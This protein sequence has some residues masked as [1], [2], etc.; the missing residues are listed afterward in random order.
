MIRSMT[1]F[2]AGRGEGAGVVVSAEVKSTNGRFL[3]LAMRL[4]PAL[5]ARE[6]ELDALV[7]T[8]LR[9]GSAALKVEL[10]EERPEAVVKVDEDVVR[11]YQTVFRRLGVS[12]EPLATLPGVLV[13]VRDDLPDDAFA[14]VRD[15]ISSALDDL[16]RM[17]EREGR[18]LAEAL[19]GICDRIGELAAALRARAPAVVHEYKDKLSARIAA[20]VEGFG[21]SLDAQLLARE[22]ALFADR[23]DIT[24]E[25]DR[26]AS[27]LA[28]IKELLAH[29]E[30][31]GRTLEFLSQEMLREA[32]TVGSKSADAELSR[33]VVQLK[34]EI[35]RFK[36]Q[37]ANVE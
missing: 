32:N 5:S 37:I 29:G 14:V 28:Q 23:C 12:E 2:G 33:L 15:A 17:R 4:P 8:R 26:L 24:E 19:G 35:E 16:V 21:G 9:R 1:G 3:K 6:Q 11:A 7:R 30:E 13:G 25:L 22:V 31:A 18:A 27:H 34:T 10:R 36:E 20:L